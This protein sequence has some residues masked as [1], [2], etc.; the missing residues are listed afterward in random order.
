MTRIE[1]KWTEAR[2]TEDSVVSISNMFLRPT[3]PNL[4]ALSDKA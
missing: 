4:E 3:L 2:V 1:K